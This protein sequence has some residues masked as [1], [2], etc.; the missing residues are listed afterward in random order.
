MTRANTM[1]RR[2][3][4]LQGSFEL[5]RELSESVI[6][7]VEDR[8]F[9]MAPSPPV[10]VALS[11][12]AR[13]QPSLKLQFFL[14]VTAFEDSP[15]GA[16]WL[17]SSLQIKA[18]VASTSPL[19]CHAFCLP[20]PSLSHDRAEGFAHADELGLHMLKLSGSVQQCIE[21]CSEGALPVRFMVSKC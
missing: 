8:H 20:V 5:P 21:S 1:S 2:S 4:C 3:F 14:N 18:A 17:P 19:P 15:S 16:L 11:A 13:D 9:Y 12:S 7:L 6:Y 10:S